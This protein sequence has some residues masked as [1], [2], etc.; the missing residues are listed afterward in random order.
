MSDN[1]LRI[2]FFSGSHHLLPILKDIFDHQNNTIKNILDKQLQLLDSKNLIYPNSKEKLT[3]LFSN[4]ELTT[5]LSKKILLNLVITQP[6]RKN[7]NKIIINPIKKYALEKEIKYFTPEKINT[8]LDIWKKHN[9]L[10]DVLIDNISLVASFGQ[11][12]SSQVLEISN[13]GFINWHPSLLPK[14]RG[15]TPIQ[16]SLINQEKITGL[17]WMQVIKK[18]DAGNILLQVKKDI[19]ESD[20]FFSLIDYF[21]N[22]GSNTWLI[23]ILLQILNQKNQIT[24]LEQNEQAA[25]FCSKI[26]KNLKQINPLEL[27]TA[28]LFARFKAFVEF[29]TTWILDDYF[30]TELKLNKVEQT[31]FVF[32][33]KNELIEFEN[34]KIQPDFVSD[35][36]LQITYQK[37]KITFLKCLDGIIEIKEITLKNG[38]KI[39]FSGFS[40]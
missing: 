34:Q 27:K 33:S 38:K 14:Y 24:G 36:W 17:S 29:P 23:A 18:M 37:Q 21:S 5:F 15:A 12:L 3:K 22:I 19:K 7:G 16:S 6:D 13:F 8:E 28:E 11:I 31:K 40:F 4:L 32:D 20:N 26:D 39:N 9:Q 25:T 30:K 10:D 1:F 2:N 35:N